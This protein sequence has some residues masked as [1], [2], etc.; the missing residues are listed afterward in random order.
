VDQAE[1]DVLGTDEF[2]VE[3]PGLFL[4]KDEHTSS[5]VSE[6]FEQ[7]ETSIWRLL[8]DWVQAPRPKSS[9]TGVPVRQL[10]DVC[11]PPNPTARWGCR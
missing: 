2:M 3:L 5:P 7:P 1:Q 8:S 4:R 11:G 10:I 9:P 6:S